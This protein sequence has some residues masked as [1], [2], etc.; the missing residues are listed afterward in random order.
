[1]RNITRNKRQTQAHTKY[2]TTSISSLNN[3][4]HF[5][6]WTTIETRQ[7]PISIYGSVTINSFQCKLISVCVAI[8]CI[9]SVFFSADLKLKVMVKLMAMVASVNIYLP[10]SI[11]LLPSRL[12]FNPIPHCFCVGKSSLLIPPRIHGRVSTGKARASSAAAVVETIPV[13]L[14]LSL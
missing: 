10:P 6:F 14:S 11:A 7:L 8:H 5:Y 12:S 1:M 3:Y 4:Q 2:T 13:T 9:R